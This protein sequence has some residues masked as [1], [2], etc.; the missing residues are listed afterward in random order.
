MCSI[1]YVVKV[2]SQVFPPP[3][4]HLMVTWAP[5][6]PFPPKLAHYF[7]SGT[8]NELGKVYLSF[9]GVP[10]G[11]REIMFE[12]ARQRSEAEEEGYGLRLLLT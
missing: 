8:R 9:G 5:L 1:V 4:C 11:R 7:C 2:I 6:L 12:G 3:A 10:L